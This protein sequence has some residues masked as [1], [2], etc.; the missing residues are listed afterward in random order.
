MGHFLTSEADLERPSLKSG[1]AEL[2][3]ARIRGSS[4]DSPSKPV[5]KKARSS[6]HPLSSSPLNTSRDEVAPLTPPVLF[7]RPMKPPPSVSPNTNLR[8]H[9]KQVKDLLGTP[10][11]GILTKYGYTSTPKAFSPA[12]LDANYG[13][14]TEGLDFA[15]LFPNSFTPEQPSAKRPATLQRATTSTG[16]LAS[17]TSNKLGSPFG[18]PL[19]PFTA[20]NPTKKPRLGSPVKTLG[21]PAKSAPTS[22]PDFLNSPSFDFTVGGSTP[23]LHI[24]GVDTS[25]LAGDLAVDFLADP[26]VSTATDFDLSAFADLHSDGSEEGFDMLQGFGKIGAPVATDTSSGTTVAPNGSPIKQ[27][28]R[29]TFGRSNTVHF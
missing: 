27:Q 8:N 9:R 28:Q 3:I 10:D 26:G 20:P 11:R 2:E 12:F 6:G 25:D 5:H 13:W 29:P 19:D 4:Y 14:S 23:K 21:A 18:G 16:V 1:R 17:M 24:G 15:D 22:N 7:K